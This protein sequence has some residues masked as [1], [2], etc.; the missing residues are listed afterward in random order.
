MHYFIRPHR[1]LIYWKL[2]NKRI[3]RT[4]LFSVSFPCKKLGGGG[5]APEESKQAQAS[6]FKVNRRAVIFLYFIPMVLV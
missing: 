3:Y 4:H 2:S 6:C 1:P 5:A